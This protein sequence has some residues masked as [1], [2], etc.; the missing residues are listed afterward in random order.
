[1]KSECFIFVF[2]T[3]GVW[4]QNKKKYNQESRLG[5]LLMHQ[6]RIPEVS[7]MHYADAATP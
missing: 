3:G 2:E 7:Y 5:D 6:Q 4:N 1:M